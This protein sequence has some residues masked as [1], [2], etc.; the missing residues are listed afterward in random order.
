M[1]FPLTSWDISLWLAVVAI[2]LLTTAELMPEHYGQKKLLINKERIEKTGLITGM[3]FLFAV[4]LR[5]IGVI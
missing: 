1:P 5:I 3:I 2:I 4:V